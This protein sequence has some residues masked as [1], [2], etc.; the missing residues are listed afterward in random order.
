MDILFPIQKIQ[1]SIKSL[2]QRKDLA[3]TNELKKNFLDI[4]NV[5]TESCV[6]LN[7]EDINNC[8]N[9]T[10]LLKDL[11][12]LFNKEM[13][14]FIIDKYNSLLEFNS[15]FDII[16]DSRINEIIKLFYVIYGLTIN[17]SQS[18]QIL[19]NMLSTLDSIVDKLIVCFNN[20]KQQ[21]TIGSILLLLKIQSGIFLNINSFSGSFINNLVNITKIILI[22]RHNEE[23]QEQVNLS[24]FLDYKNSKISDI[25]IVKSF[26]ENL[27]EFTFKVHKAD[28]N[29]DVL[30]RKIFEFLP[31]WLKSYYSSFSS[32]SIKNKSIP[33]M[34]LVI[35][36]Q[37]IKSLEPDWESFNVRDEETINK[38]MTKKLQRNKRQ[39]TRN[40]KKQSIIITQERNEKLKYIGKLRAEDDKFRN[41]FLE[42]A[43]VEAKQIAT[44][45]VKKRHKLRNNKGKGNK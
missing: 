9:F 37:E 13:N 20:D 43:A 29:F 1:E 19:S 39:L 18:N 22:D 26:L 12:F 25:N 8:I 45:N 30:F 4:L 31:N 5:L 38:S 10:T 24:S 21:N 34:F 35:K 6:S 33:I 2:E 7:I 23:N 36:T 42:Q 41:Q 17:L 28:I 11:S 44:T 27:I 3:L 32:N 14:V 15:N 40:L 16:D